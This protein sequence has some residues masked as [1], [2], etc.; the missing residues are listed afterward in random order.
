[1]GIFLLGL[2]YF[3]II[4]TL[5]F[6]PSLLAQKSKAQERITLVN[7]FFGATGIGW[8]LSLLWALGERF[9]IPGHNF[10]RNGKWHKYVLW[11]SVMVFMGIWDFKRTKWTKVFCDLS[12]FKKDQLNFWDIASLKWLPMPAQLL[13]LLF[14]AWLIFRPSRNKEGCPLIH[15][16]APTAIMLFFLS[17]ARPSGFWYFSLIW[18]SFVLYGVIRKDAEETF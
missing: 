2:F 12:V 9:K 8:V 3:F 5:F 15:Y 11:L 17:I 1:M 6:L 4:L 7:V 18:G 14:L 10:V 16:A 13:I